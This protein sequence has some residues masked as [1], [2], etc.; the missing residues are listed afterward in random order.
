MNMS[1]SGGF[2]LTGVK[3]CPITGKNELDDSVVKALKAQEKGRRGRA[4]KK[5]KEAKKKRAG[6]SNESRDTKRLRKKK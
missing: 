6:G 2:I 5:S 1:Q 4:R 3:L